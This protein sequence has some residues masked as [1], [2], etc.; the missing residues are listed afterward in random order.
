MALRT[1]DPSLIREVN[2][3]LALELV[4]DRPRSRTDIPATGLNKATVT[5]LVD[6]LIADGSVREAGPGPGSMG[7]GPVL[8]E[9][10]PDAGF[11]IG[12]ELAVRYLNVIVTDFQG[13][14]LAGGEAPIAAEDGPDAA[15]E[16]LIALIK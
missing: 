15:I 13:Q 2:R 1:G 11:L 16:R 4:R 12:A 8:L 5:A 9:V 6:R 14:R 10:D 3:A 7:R